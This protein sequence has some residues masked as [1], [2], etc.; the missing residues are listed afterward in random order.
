[1]SFFPLS[2]EQLATATGLPLGHVRYILALAAV[3]PLALVF[4]LLSRAGHS[5]PAGSAGVAIIKHLYSI[6]VSSALGAYAMGH[7]A[8]VHP[9]I[10]TTISWLLLCLLPHGVAHKAVFVVRLRFFFPNPFC[11]LPI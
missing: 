3:C 4:R 2:S 9:F 8:W 1:M 6:V 7:E 10:S 11:H 5:S